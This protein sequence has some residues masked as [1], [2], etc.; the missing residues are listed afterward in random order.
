MDLSTILNA[1][2]L[3]G[4]LVGAL[5]EIRALFDHAVSLLSETDQATAKAELA[6]IREA[7][8]DLHNRLQAKLAAAAQR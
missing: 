2:R 1:A 7:N 3:L 6:A 8:D 4:P 5:P